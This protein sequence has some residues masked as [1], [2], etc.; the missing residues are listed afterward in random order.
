MGSAQPCGYVTGWRPTVSRSI[1]LTGRTPLRL[2]AN[3]IVRQCDELDNGQLSMVLALC[4]KL[5]E[6]R[7]PLSR[8]LTHG[9]PKVRGLL[10]QRA[11]VSNGGVG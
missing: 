10:F 1:D 3:V 11:F 6:W 4:R 8:D 9:M 7:A 5:Q 2:A